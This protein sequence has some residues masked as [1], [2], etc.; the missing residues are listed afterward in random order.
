MCGLHCYCEWGRVIECVFECEGRMI[1]N[2][3]PL[4]FL[5]LFSNLS[6]L[7]DLILIHESQLLKNTIRAR[8]KSFTVQFSSN[9]ILESRIG[10]NFSHG[11]YVIRKQETIKST[12]KTKNAISGFYISDWPIQSIFSSFEIHHSICSKKKKSII[13]G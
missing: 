3:C 10:S 13:Q 11:L 2:F 1:D 8:V 7:W 5:E 12:Q 4:F 6:L 9:P